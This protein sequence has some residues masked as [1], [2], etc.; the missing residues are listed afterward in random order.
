MKRGGS[1]SHNDPLTV[2]VLGAAAYRAIISEMG[3]TLLLGRT[4]KR[5][6]RG[7]GLRLERLS[8]RGATFDR[9]GR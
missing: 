5:H 3:V 7:R 9:R 8:S 1:A 2:S 4:A 6:G